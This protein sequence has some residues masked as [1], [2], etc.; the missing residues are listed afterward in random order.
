MR[1]LNTDRLRNCQI[2]IVYMGQSGFKSR[3]KYI[4]LTRNRSNKGEGEYKS[5]YCKEAMARHRGRALL[6][7]IVGSHC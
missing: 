7:G 4:P 2:H 3:K 5:T 6:L 1:K